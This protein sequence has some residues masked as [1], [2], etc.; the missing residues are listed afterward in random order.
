V[1]QTFGAE[2]D[3]IRAALELLLREGFEDAERWLTEGLSAEQ[4]P[5]R[6]ADV[7]EDWPAGDERRGETGQA[8]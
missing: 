4:G 6:M 2:T 8:G 3:V 7:D 1:R 5:G